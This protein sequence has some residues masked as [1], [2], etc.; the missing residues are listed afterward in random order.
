VS[1]TVKHSHVCPEAHWISP[2]G[3]DVS[4]NVPVPPRLIGTTFAK[5]VSAQAKVAPI[6]IRTMLSF[7]AMLISL[8]I[9]GLFFL[10]NN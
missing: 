5:A 9:L 1:F 4:V 7:L 6:A 8:V 3:L 2:Q 10:W